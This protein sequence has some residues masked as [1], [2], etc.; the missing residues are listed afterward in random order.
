MDYAKHFGYNKEKSEA[1]FTELVSEVKTHDLPRKIAMIEAAQSG[2]DN[3]AG[4][5]GH[6]K[7]GFG[8]QPIQ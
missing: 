1:K 4:N 7:G 5:E 8:E 6:M 3:T 2:G